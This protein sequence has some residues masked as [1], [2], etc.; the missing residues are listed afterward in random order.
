MKMR[1]GMMYLPGDVVLIPF[2]FSNLQT[3][4]K[5]PVL[6]FQSADFFGDMVC[7]AVTSRSNHQ[8]S[9]PVY[10][11]SFSD[12][13]LPK[14]SW[15]RYGKIY[16]LNESVVIGQFGTLKKGVFDKICASFCQHFSC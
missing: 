4:K 5:R 16:T 15:I 1:F 7:L 6:V 12:G 8:Q 13:V 10:D 9:V 14:P 11:D 2:P 3:A